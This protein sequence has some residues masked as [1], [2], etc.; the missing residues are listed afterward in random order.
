MITNVKGVF[1][2]FEGSA[3]AS[4]DKF[5]TSEIEFSLKSVSVDTGAAD[6]DGHL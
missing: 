1:K 4:N 5:I 6:R 2:Q 3:L